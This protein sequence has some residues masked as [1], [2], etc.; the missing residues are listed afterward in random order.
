M[1]IEEAS[2]WYTES[3][4]VY[5]PPLLPNAPGFVAYLHENRQ[6]LGSLYRSFESTTHAT[7][8]IQVISR[9]QTT[10]SPLPGGFFSATQMLLFHLTKQAGNNAL[11]V[12]ERYGMRH[13][14]LIGANLPTLPEIARPAYRHFQTALVITTQLQE[15]GRLEE[16]QAA[17]ALPTYRDMAVLSAYNNWAAEHPG[18]V[19]T[20]RQLHQLVPN[21]YFV[22]PKRAVAEIRAS[23]VS[24][25][26]STER[27]YPLEL[28]IKQPDVLV[29]PEVF[30]ARRRQS[31]HPLS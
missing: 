30:S 5:A 6:D 24:L 25:T 28:A 22:N 12:Q 3:S 9:L 27:E 19:P 18:K 23:L 15:N 29:Q 1:A 11:Q 2:N 16:V 21:S 13:T 10:P 26:L 31:T 4:G 20:I 17:G 7:L 14:A 8:P